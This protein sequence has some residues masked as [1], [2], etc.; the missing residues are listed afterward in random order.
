MKACTGCSFSADIEPAFDWGGALHIALRLLC[1]AC[2]PITSR[3]RHR[4]EAHPPT[5][6]AA[7]FPQQQMGAAEGTLH[8]WIEAMACAAPNAAVRRQA[9]PFVGATYAAARR[10]AFLEAVA[11]F[12]SYE[13]PVGASVVHSMP[14][15]RTVPVSE[16]F[17][18]LALVDECVHLRTTTQHGTEPDTLPQCALA[19]RAVFCS[20]VTSSD[21]DSVRCADWPRLVVNEMVR[22][23][24]CLSKGRAAEARVSL[25]MSEPPLNPASQSP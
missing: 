24:T 10:Q 22:I 13:P 9:L 21:G 1:L 18:W 14:D 8:S 3:K 4:L 12:R 19:L 23:A 16:R 11:C 6:H 20:S 17:Q 7:A 5:P 2:R 15:G 25:E